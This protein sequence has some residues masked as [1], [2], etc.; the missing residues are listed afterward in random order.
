MQVGILFFCFV[1]EWKI[2]RK[3][4]QTKLEEKKKALI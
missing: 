2:V 1:I 3:Y 4:I